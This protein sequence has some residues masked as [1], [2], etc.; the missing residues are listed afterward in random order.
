VTPGIAWLAV[1]WIAAVP[2]GRRYKRQASDTCGTP[3][4][5][6]LVHF[7]D[8]ADLVG[9]SLQPGGAG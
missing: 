1:A 9:P 6:P 2:F 8:M 7:A 3:G 4:R 5:V